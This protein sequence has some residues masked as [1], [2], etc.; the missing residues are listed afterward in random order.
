M[1]KQEE[2]T[3]LKNQRE[4][5]VKAMKDPHLCEGTASLY[6]RVSGYYRNV[7]AMNIGKQQE[8]K[9]RKNFVI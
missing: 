6:S 8:V 1:S 4:A 3:N 5:I 7:S 9:D 2:I